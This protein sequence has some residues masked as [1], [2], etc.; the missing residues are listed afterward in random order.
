MTKNNELGDDQDAPAGSRAESAD[1]GQSDS[2]D[3]AGSADSG[4]PD[5]AGARHGGG[6]SYETGA[7]E[8]RNGRLAGTGQLTVK[9]RRFAEYT[10]E[11]YTAQESLRRAGYDVAPK[12]APQFAYQMRKH[13]G[14][15]RHMRAHR[16]HWMSGRIAADAMNVIH[17]LINDESTPAA[18]RFAAARYVLDR[19]DERD[20]E[21]KSHENKDL[22]EMSR[23]ELERIVRDAGAQAVR[24]A[25]AID[26][27]ASRVEP[28]DSAPD[29]APDRD[30]DPLTD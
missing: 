8:L 2:T 7:V 25:D 28:S 10:A 15:Q 17:G 4:Q 9:Q 5:S 26:G 22:H 24:Q 20:R 21:D 27:T 30:D 3:A 19:A 29:S 12:N 1:S 6:V 18:T 14:I 16:K 23:Q 11:G 13:P